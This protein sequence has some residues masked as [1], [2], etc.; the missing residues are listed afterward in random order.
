MAIFFCEDTVMPITST[1]ELETLKA[2]GN[3][4]DWLERSHVDAL[5]HMTFTSPVRREIEALIQEFDARPI[6]EPA[7]RRMVL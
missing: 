5:R 7:Q 3:F 4:M 6:E 1:I 2:K